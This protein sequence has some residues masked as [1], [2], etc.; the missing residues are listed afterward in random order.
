MCFA[1]SWKKEGRIKNTGW[2]EGLERLDAVGSTS[3]GQQPASA[4]P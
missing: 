1:F 4:G 2:G 3:G